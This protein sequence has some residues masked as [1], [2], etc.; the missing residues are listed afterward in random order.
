MEPIR[1]DTTH[2]SPAIQQH[3]VVCS[4]QRRMERERKIDLLEKQRLS[5]ARGCSR[6]TFS[7]A[8]LFAALVAAFANR[9]EFC[10]GGALLIG[11][12]PGA[13]ITNLGECKAARSGKQGR[14]LS[15][16]RCIPSSEY[17]AARSRP[18]TDGGSRNP[19]AKCGQQPLLQSVRGASQATTVSQMMPHRA[20]HL[21]LCKCRCAPS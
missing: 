20:K 19:L 17:H 15:N 13:L 3:I 1:F 7:H 12:L 8:H 9:K 10:N 14:S 2:V 21:Q 11:Q 18:T 6:R 16:A 4:L 5:S